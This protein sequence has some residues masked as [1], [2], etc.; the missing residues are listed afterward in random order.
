MKFADVA[1]QMV[2]YVAHFWF[3]EILS[4]CDGVSEATDHT[5]QALKD[6]HRMCT[7]LPAFFDYCL[8]A[9][10]GLGCSGMLV[11]PMIAWWE[12]CQVGP[13]YMAP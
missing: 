12:A 3:D 6:I 4:I 11:Q 10:K 5:H 7:T 9:K 1:A 2:A 8:N 13:I